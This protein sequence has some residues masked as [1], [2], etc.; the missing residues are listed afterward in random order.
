MSQLYNTGPCEMYTGTL[1]GSQ[2]ALEFL[3]YSENGMNIEFKSYY[4]DVNSDLLGPKIPTD[5]QHFQADGII[6]GDLVRWNETVLAQCEDRSRLGADAGGTGTGAAQGVVSRLE[7]G[8]L[9]QAYG[10]TYRLLCDAPSLNLSSAA[11]LFPGMSAINWLHVYLADTM[12]R[13][14]GAR[15]ERLHVIFRATVNVTNLSP[16]GSFSNT[17]TLYDGNRAG[18]GGPLDVSSPG[19]LAGPN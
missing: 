5:I 15:V 2:L 1:P 6:S 11:T 9:M 3:G 7:V 14:R 10:K 16:S 12:T 13:K 4:E 8:A 19:N 18:L 17:F